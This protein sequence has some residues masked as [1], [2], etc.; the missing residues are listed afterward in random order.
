MGYGLLL[1][2]MMCLFT[3]IGF[4]FRAVRGMNKLISLADMHMELI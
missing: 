1:K 4:A 2:I 3:L